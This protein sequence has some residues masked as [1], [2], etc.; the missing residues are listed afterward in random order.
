MTIQLPFG[1]VPLDLGTITTG[2]A[3][4]NRPAAHLGYFKHIGLVWQSTGAS[5]LWVRGDFGAAMPVDFAAMISA[6]AL[7]GTTIRLR[8]DSAPIDTGAVLYDS[9]ALPF[10]DPTI[11]RVDGLYHSHLELEDVVTARYWRIDIGGHTGDFT[12]TTMVLGERMQ[13]ANFYDKDYKFDT[14]DLGTFDVTRWG[15][16]DEAAGLIFRSLALK[17]SWISDADYETKFRPL[18]ERLG[19]RGV[20]YWCHDPEPSTARQAKTYLG[21]F[22]TLPYATGAVQAGRYESDFQ[23]LSM[24]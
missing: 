7:P 16:P 24:I 18:A 5:N 22:K 17:F 15:V 12:A 9:G 20:L 23:I 19:K 14:A 3:R 13:P 1:V 10:I 11:T 8:L 6:T 4:A 2:N 21:W